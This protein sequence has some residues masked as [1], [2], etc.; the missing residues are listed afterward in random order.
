MHI[1]NFDAD[2]HRED[3]CIQRMSSMGASLRCDE[4]LEHE[5]SNI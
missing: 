2:L 4:W 1:S 5:F 3:R